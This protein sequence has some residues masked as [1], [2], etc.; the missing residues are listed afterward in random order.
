MPRRSI[1]SNAVVYCVSATAMLVLLICDALPQQ[2]RRDRDI[3]RPL[4]S[5]QIAE[6]VLPSVVLVTTE[7]ADTG[8][9]TFGSGFV[10]RRGIIVTNKHVVECG[11]IGRVKSVG[12]DDEHR[13]IAKWIDPQHDLALLK[14]EGLDAP[15]LPLAGAAQLAVGDDVYVA[16]NPKGFEGTFS[17]GIISGLRLRE[18]YIQFDAPISPGSSG[19]PVVDERGRV[20]GVTVSYVEGQNL[21]FAVPAATIPPLLAR[22]SGVADDVD[23]ARSSAARGV[24]DASNAPSSHAALYARFRAVK[25]TDPAAALEVARAYLQSDAAPHMHVAELR[26]FLALHEETP[27]NERRYQ[28]DITNAGVGLK[29]GGTFKRAHELLALMPDSVYAHL[30]MS[31]AAYVARVEGSLADEAAH[32][33]DR[34]L[35]LLDE[36][37]VLHIPKSLFSPPHRMDK[38]SRDVLLGRLHQHL[39]YFRMDRD[40]KASGDHFGRAV[41]LDPKLRDEQIRTGLVEAPAVELYTGGECDLPKTPALTGRG[42][43]ATP[44]GMEKLAIMR[45]SS[46]RPARDIPPYHLIRY[47][48]VTMR[49]VI[50]EEGWVVWTE[51]VEGPAD[52]YESARSRALTWRFRPATI[53]G[54]RVKVVGIR[55]FFIPLPAS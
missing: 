3:S 39:G 4:T 31:E 11:I 18:G 20:V 8:K 28:H 48:P 42:W 44:E 37:A 24:A 22:S 21:N 52:L 38:V 41:K 30:E 34:A 51:P 12:G 43:C 13:V 15:A 49:V 25:Y 47:K 35:Q 1:R 46:L 23:S 32:I 53:D 9:V 6:R 2:R 19:G 55:D 27:R 7:C 16:G 14:V 17:R 5:R 29:L 54:R 33:A 50:D 40:P 36:G 10:V 45:Y 26:R